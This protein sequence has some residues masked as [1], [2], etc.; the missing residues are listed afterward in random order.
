[1]VYSI[2][3]ERHNLNFYM[4]LPQK[5]LFIT[6]CFFSAFAINLLNAEIKLSEKEQVAL[7]AQTQWVLKLIQSNHYLK[8]DIQSIDG[9]QIIENFAN[10]LDYSKLYFLKTDIDDYLFRFSESIES[11]LENGNLYPAFVI[12]NDYISKFKARTEWVLDRLDEPFVFKEESLFESD[13]TEA[14]WINSQKEADTTWNAF[15]HYQVLNELL[16][17]TGEAM[18]DSDNE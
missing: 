4:K 5:S 17:I 16:S 8:N 6:L 2:N 1:M 7:K 14:L 18:E 11:F 12:Y 15:I 9:T 3:K 10:S 13:R